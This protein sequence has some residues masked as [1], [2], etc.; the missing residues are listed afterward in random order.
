[1]KRTARIEFFLGMSLWTLLPG[2]GIAESGSSG[3][4]PLKLEA[5]G[6]YCL[7]QAE[8]IQHVD[9]ASLN[10]WDNPN[11]VGVAIRVTWAVTE[12]SADQFDWSYL[13]EALRL[14]RLKKKFIA[15]SVVA[16]IRSPDWVFGSATI[17][18]LTGKAARHRDTVPAPWDPNYLNA[19][20]TFV[21]AFGARYDGNSLIS[22]VTATGLGRGEECHLLDDPNDTGQFDANRWLGAAN[23]IVNCYNSAFKITPW[24]LAWG[25][26]ALHQ[27]QLMAD[28]YTESGG[29]GF[30]ADNLFV[31][32][33]NPGVSPGRLALRMSRSH[34]VVFQA[35]RPAHDPYTLAAVLE[36]GR[37][38]GMQ[39]FE[40]Y[41]NDVSD[42]ACQAVLAAANRAMGGR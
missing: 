1:M 36:N 33:P 3:S 16:G 37:R 9:L 29:F 10:C 18:R 17:L 22:Y 19:W 26:P 13:E 23:Q 42:P 41:Q 2:S 12:P 38:I 15:I 25:Q 4:A 14:A 27:N 30:K 39:A 35:L 11:I 8:G 21:Q 34:P 24:V 7:T 6:I 5:R 20:K 28:L 40:C 31:F 32:F